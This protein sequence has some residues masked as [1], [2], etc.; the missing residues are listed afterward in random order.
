[1]QSDLVNRAV[2]ECLTGLESVYTD[3]IA[4]I[5]ADS[6]ALLGSDRMTPHR[7]SQ[8]VQEAAG[9]S[10]AVVWCRRVVR[11]AIAVLDDAG[12]TT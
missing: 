2:R 11:A 6:Q 10:D 3:R 12:R 1:M 9:A 7:R 8:I 4:R 5:A